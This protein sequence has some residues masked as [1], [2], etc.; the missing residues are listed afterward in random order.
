MYV[1]LSYMGARHTD[2]LSAKL[3]ET[4]SFMLEATACASLRRAGYTVTYKMHP[5]SRTN[6]HAALGSLADEVDA[7]HFDACQH[8]H[9]CLIFDY[10]GSAFFDA[11]ATNGGIVLIDTGNRPLDQNARHDLGERC[12]I[13]ETV[14]DEQNRITFD[15]VA[16]ATAI[17][18]AIQQS[19]F[20][21]S[22]YEKYFTA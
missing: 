12:Q 22:F 18:I 15:P 11:L 4:L 21:T 2:S 5:S 20:P 1:G 16:L 7:S 10:A 14:V 17:E 6:L 13:V 3:P 19:E 8:D 9:D